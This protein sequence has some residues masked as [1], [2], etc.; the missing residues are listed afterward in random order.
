MEIIHLDAAD[1]PRLVAL[2]QL[3]ELPYRPHGRD[4]QQAFEQQLDSGVQ[5]VLAAVED[6]ALVGAITVT[7]DSRKGWLNRLAVDPDRRRQGIG[8]SLI[9]A[10]EE[11]L[12]D[13]GITVIAALIF[14]ENEVS[15]AV[16]ESA[17]YQSDP[18]IL[19]Y[20]KRNSWDD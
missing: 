17:G 7:H 3:A 2:W 4:S 15:Q 5:K 12:H 1:Y 8:R 11:Y 10:A 20:S 16:F 13:R 9:A 19:Y 6:G 14:E 18:R